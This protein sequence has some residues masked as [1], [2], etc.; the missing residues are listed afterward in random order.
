MS[1]PD[2][3]LYT[4]PTHQG[5]KES[6]LRCYLVISVT[7]KRNRLIY[8]PRVMCYVNHL[9]KVPRGVKKALSKSPMHTPQQKE[10]EVQVFSS[11][12]QRENK[13][14]VLQDKQLLSFWN[15]NNEGTAEPFW[16]LLLLKKTED[17]DIMS[18][19]LIFCTL[20]QRIKCTI[21]TS[22]LKVILPFQR[23]VL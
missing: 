22:I 5:E 3:C 7:W 16:S 20:Q 23:S 8:V 11:K 10:T 2:T 19:N 9:K 14:L 15:C 6:I 21:P 1:S 4:N 12:T 18:P 17:K 13:F